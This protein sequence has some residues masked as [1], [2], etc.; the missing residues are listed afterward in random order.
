MSSAFIDVTPVIDAVPGRSVPPALLGAGLVMMAV[1]LLSIGYGFAATGAAYTWGA[2]L[3]GLLYLLAL[4]QGAAVYCA[5]LTSTWGR[6]G[7]PMKRIAEAYMLLMP[8]AYLALLVFLLFGLG[9]YKWNPATII[10]GGAYDLAPHSPEAI[11]IKPIWFSKGFYFA[12]LLGGFGFLMILD[13]IY[14]RASLAPDLLMAKLRLGNKAPAWWN[15]IIGSHT[16]VEK[17]VEAGQ[18][19]QTVVSPVIII[20]SGY[21]L[22]IMAIDLVMSLQPSWAGNLFPGWLSMSSFWL[23]LAAIGAMSMLLRDWLG[24]KGI[25]RANNTHDLGKLMLAGCMFWGYTTFAQIIPIWYTNMPEETDFLLIR[26]MLPAWGGLARVVAALCFVAP[27]TILLSRGLK[28]MQWPFFGICAL[29][30]VGLFLER[31]LLVLPQV[32]FGDTFPMVSFILVNV[33]VWIGVLGL[34]LTAMTQFLARVP[35]AVITDPDLQTHPWD[36]HIGSLDRAHH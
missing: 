30:M 12:R 16:S 7:R 35:A 19:T 9:I 36:V 11:A 17:A 4:A 21:I 29:I 18:H 22:T 14:V 24:L 34:A 27:F 33:G 6:W 31:S 26:M 3:V 15:S 28:K 20:A 23:S 2:I 1:G 32:Y 5:M 25:I 10:P 13:L 8:I